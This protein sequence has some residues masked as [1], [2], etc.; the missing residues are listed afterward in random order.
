MSKKYK[1]AKFEIETDPI[2]SKA[3]ATEQ[4]NRA[5][6]FFGHKNLRI[7]LHEHI[8]GNNPGLKY[9]I[10][11]IG[12]KKAEDVIVAESIRL[13]GCEIPLGVNA[14]DYMTDRFAKKQ[15]WLGMKGRLDGTEEL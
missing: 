8:R 12:G 2:Y 15:V 4:F 1:K 11:T 3:S 10:I 13:D 5:K 9:Y 6:Q 14:M 7:F